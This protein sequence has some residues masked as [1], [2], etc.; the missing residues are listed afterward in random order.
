MSLCLTNAGAQFKIIGLLNVA[1]ENE[2]AIDATQ[3]Q[4]H[5]SNAQGRGFSV[6]R[7]NV[8]REKPFSPP[9]NAQNNFIKVHIIENDSSTT[10]SSSK[11]SQHTK[12]GKEKE[13]KKNKCTDKFRYAPVRHASSSS[14]IQSQNLSL[15]SVTAN[16]TKTYQL[17]RRPIKP[18]A[19]LLM[20]D[21]FRRRQQNSLPDNTSQAIYFNNAID[22]KLHK[23]AKYRNHYK[24]KCS[25][26]RIS[27][28]PKI[29]ISVS[30]CK[31]N[32]FLCCK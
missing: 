19:R 22:L 24:S 30:R 5:Q 8:P 25:C 13:K 31:P 27:N 1:A 28:C 16:L 7:G 15:I 14:L 11:P 26:E 20:A 18:P 4:P 23:N 21:T 2:V 12:N 29:Q 9:T 6:V 32:Y 10:L 17:R 3:M